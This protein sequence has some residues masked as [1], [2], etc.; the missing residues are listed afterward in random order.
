MPRNPREG[1]SPRN[2]ASR[3]VI[4]APSSSSSAT[5]TRALLD[6]IE[7]A[8]ARIAELEAELANA[9]AP[10]AVPADLGDGQSTSPAGT[11][12]GKVGE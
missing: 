3:R 12:H 9:K 6:Q 2:N 4:V 8:H 10:K 1:S 7:A 11:D 5:R